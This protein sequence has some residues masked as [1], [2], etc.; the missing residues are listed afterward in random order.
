MSDKTRKITL[1]GSTKFKT[2]FEVLNKQLTLEGN[3][4]YS[5][6]FFG[7]ADKILLTHEQKEI[8][9][10]IHKKK[11][12]NSDGIFVIDV[13]GYIG[14]S[15]QSEIDYAKHTNKFIKYLSDFP[16]LKTLC[17]SAT[18]KLSNL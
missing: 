10:D 17:D 13:E 16:D 12:E 1:C 6:A 15:T 9:D 14:S 18:M 8:L 4:V 7:H 3:V 5:V 2:E 11:I